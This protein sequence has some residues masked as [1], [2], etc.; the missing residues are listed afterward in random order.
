[1][2][3]WRAL[4]GWALLKPTPVHILI[5]SRTST[6]VDLVLAAILEIDPSIKMTFIQVDLSDHNSVR[7][8]A[9]QILASTRSKIDVV[10]NSAGNMAL[11]EYTVDKQGIEMQMLANHVGHF[12]LTNLQ[13]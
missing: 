11:K 9:R 5:A 2:G 1:M 12:L 10:I 8:A 13:V 4:M 6:K 7:W 3:A